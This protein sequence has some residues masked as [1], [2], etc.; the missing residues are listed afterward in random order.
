MNVSVIMSFKV[1]PSESRKISVNMI[2]SINE[3]QYE[4]ERESECEVEVE[5]DYTF[6]C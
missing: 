5:Q 1:N 3:T 6:E 2:R 4:F